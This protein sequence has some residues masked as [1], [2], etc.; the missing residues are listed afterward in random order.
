MINKLLTLLENPIIVIA[1]TIII[2]VVL[3]TQKNLVGK[4]LRK[5]LKLNTDS[6]TIKYA[7][8]ISKRKPNFHTETQKRNYLKS[9]KSD[10][11]GG[12]PD[13]R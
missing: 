11:I 13:D 9:F 7:D 5:Y 1:L 4:L 12:R 6:E 8:N 10:L 3:L 2:I